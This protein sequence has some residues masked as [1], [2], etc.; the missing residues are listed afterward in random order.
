M[1]EEIIGA[2]EEIMPRR[3]YADHYNEVDFWAKLERLPRASVKKIMEKALLLRELLLAPGTP[4]W[5]RGAII[6][7]L[8]YFIVPFDVIPDVPFLPATYCDDLAVM[9]L[10][11]ANLDRFVTDEIKQRVERRL[12]GGKQEEEPEPSPAE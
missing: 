12:S 8:G 5:V 11:L 2:G 7:C 10:V 3:K 1:K 4:F 6:S 9:G